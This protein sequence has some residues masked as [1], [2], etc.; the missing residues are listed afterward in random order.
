MTNLEQI[1]V[2]RGP[3]SSLYGSNA[4]SGVINLITRSPD[5]L[6]QNGRPYGFDVRALA[7]QYDTF[8]V[9]ATAAGR[10]G[11]VK[12]L[13]DYYGF[14]SN[15]PHLLNQPA[16]GVVDDNEWTQVHQV[17]AKVKVQSVSV[18]AGYSWSD[19]G[20]PGGLTVTAV[21]NCGRCHYTPNDREQVQKFWLNAQVDQKLGDWFRVYGDVYANFKGRQVT[22]ENLITNAPEDAI[23]KRRRIGAE[24]RGL[25]TSRWV[26]ITVGGDVKL[27]DVNNQNVLPA[28]QSKPLTEQIV[29]VFADGE[30]RPLPNLILGGGVRYDYY[31][32]QPRIW[33]NAS[34]QLSPRADVIYHLSRALSLRANYGRAFRAPSLAELAID[35]QMYAATLLG[36]PLLR[37]ETVDTVEAAVD[38]WPLRDFL[39][40]SL[41]GFYNFARNLINQQQIG[42]GSTSEFQ[43]I[44]TAQVAGVE[45]E[46][47]AQVRQIDAGF[48]VAYQYLYSRA[49]TTA[50]NRPGPLDYAP[51]HRVYLRAHKRFGFGL[52]VDFYGLYVGERL[53]PA[54]AFD[55]S[56]NRTSRTVLPG[57]FVANARVG[58][59]VWHGLSASVIATNL[60]NAHY[61][62]MLGFP[63]PGISVF[64]ELRAVY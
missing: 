10:A 54:I 53:D 55:A 25:F 51:R 22:L 11:P 63:A 7:G 24:A 27:D 44:G 12:A 15:G 57:Y 3:G 64:C 62:E 38:A 39:R 59:R 49:S 29:G 18:D 26:N 46:A 21:G 32:I 40:L 35:Q 13:V 48:D 30:V 58:A 2:I 23:G 5:D 61:E 28:L 60:F 43:N 17:T 33:A 41:T 42:A 34:S 19:E 47:A 9:E 16:L 50:D 52:F 45:V 14:L 4:F 20:R 1:E 37:A 6:M 31:R 8:R 36:N 56:G